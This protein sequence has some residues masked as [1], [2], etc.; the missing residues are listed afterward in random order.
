MGFGVTAAIGGLC[1]LGMFVG[2]MAIFDWGWLY[3]TLLRLLAWMA[4]SR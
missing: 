2:V 3:I 4:R 1:L